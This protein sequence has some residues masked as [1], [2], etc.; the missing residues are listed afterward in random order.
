MQLE[1]ESGYGHSLNRCF[2]KF[3]KTPEKLVEIEQIKSR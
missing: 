2:N 3:Q 1:T